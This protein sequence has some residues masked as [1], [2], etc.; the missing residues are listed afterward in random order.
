MLQKYQ[1]MINELWK[2][3]ISTIINYDVEFK[4]SENMPICRINNCGGIKSEFLELKPKNNINNTLV[5]GC[6]F[7]LKKENKTCK[8]DKLD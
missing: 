7:S 6:H 3:G 8:T 2:A 4:K 1:K 5:M